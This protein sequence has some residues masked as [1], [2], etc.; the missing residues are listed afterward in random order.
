MTG[1][2][3]SLKMYFH[4]EVGIFCVEYCFQSVH[5]YLRDQFTDRKLGKFTASYESLSTTTNHIS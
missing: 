1:S 5:F 4:L 3:E 2:I